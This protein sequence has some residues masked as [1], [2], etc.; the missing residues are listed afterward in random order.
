MSNNTIRHD[1]LLA[2]VTDLNTMILSG[3]ILPAHDKFYADGCVQMENEEMVFEGKE[4][5]RRREEEFVNNLT[6]F[7]GAEVKSVAVD[8]ENNVTFV[9]WWMDYTHKEWGVRNYQQVSVA[10]WEGDKIVHERYYGG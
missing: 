5:N 6:E 7:R 4:L 3:E 9:E 10:R 8:A 2:L 1:E